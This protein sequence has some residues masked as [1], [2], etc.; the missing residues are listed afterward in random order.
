VTGDDTFV[1]HRSDAPEGFFTT[2]AAGLAW[3]AEVTPSGG[4]RTVPVVQV[5]PTR[6]TLR[7]LVGGGATRDAAED[8]GRALAITHA[9]GASGHGAQPPGAGGKA[10]IGPLPMPVSATGTPDWAPFFAE[11]RIRPYLRLARDDGAVDRAGAE[12]IDRVCE[13]LLTGD[14]DLTGP[15]EPVARLHGDLWSGNVLWTAS[16]AVLIDPAAHGG[17]RESD[18]AMLALFGAP[19]LERILAAYHEQAP[20]T[21]GWQRRVGLHQLFPVLVHA[22]LFGSGYGG[23]AVALARRYM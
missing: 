8:F 5:E 7:R 1:K 6:I 19:H 18:L 20:L 3:L 11:Q 2:E 21:E 10:W 23:Q 9:A 16:G 14:A 17:H 13:R 15:A 22:A 4:A 12:L